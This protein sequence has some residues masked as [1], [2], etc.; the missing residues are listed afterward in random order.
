[1]LNIS[2]RCVRRVVCIGMIS[3][4]VLV[5]C[6]SISIRWR[7]LPTDGITLGS[8]ML[9]TTACCR[10]EKMRSVAAPLPVLSIDMNTHQVVKKL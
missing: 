2:D 8:A 6:L 7:Y 9:T 1:M 4:L 10:H 3:S 5:F